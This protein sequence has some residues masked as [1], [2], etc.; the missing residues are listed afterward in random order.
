MASNITAG[1]LIVSVQ[2][3][4]TN[5]KK[6]IDTAKTKMQGMTDKINANKAAITS[7]GAKFTAVGGV[8]T[9]ALFLASKKVASFADNMAKMGKRTGESAATLSSLSFAAERSGSDIATIEKAI[10]R[11]AVNALDFSKGI[12]EAK[13]AFEELGI[14]V[15]NADGSLKSGSEIL[16]DFAEATKDMTDDTKKAALAQEIF[17]RAGTALLPFFKEGRDGIAAL[18]AEAV[19]YGLA[20]T[21]VQAAQ[22]EDFMD[23]LSNVKAAFSGITKGLVDGLIPA[24]TPVINKIA[25]ITAEVGDFI[26][27][28]KTFVTILLGVAGAFG[29]IALAIGPLLLGVASLPF[30][31]SGFAA[32]SGL[33]AVGGPF[34]LGAL[35]V[36]AAITSIAMNWDMVVAVIKTGWDTILKPIVNMM[37]LAFNAV[38]EAVKLAFD[39]IWDK[40]SAVISNIW[41][42]LTHLIDGFIDGFDSVWSIV[43]TVF[44]AIFNFIAGENG[45]IGKIYSSFRWLLDKLG[46]ELPEAGDLWADIG[47]T[48]EDAAEGIKGK[49]AGMKDAFAQNMEDNREKHDEETKI[50][51]DREIAATEVI[52]KEDEKRTEFKEEQFKMIKGAGIQFNKESLNQQA[53]DFD[54]H[55]DVLG[56]GFDGFYTE[57]KESIPGFFDK[58]FEGVAQNFSDRIDEMGDAWVDS[59]SEGGKFSDVF[60]F[61]GESLE[62]T[63]EAAFVDISGN[64]LQS[65]LDTIK[66]KLLKSGIGQTITNIFSGGGGASGAISGGLGALGSGAAG[67]GSVL[68]GGAGIIA[69]TGGIAAVGVGAYYAGKKIAESLG[70][71]HTSQKQRSLKGAAKEEHLASKYA[72]IVAAQTDVATWTAANVRLGNEV[73]HWADQWGI[74]GKELTDRFGNSLMYQL[75]NDKMFKGKIP[76]ATAEQMVAI[77]KEAISLYRQGELQSID[78]ANTIKGFHAGGIIPGMLGKET[79]IQALSGEEVITRRDPR[80]STN[81]GQGMQIVITGNNISSMLDIDTVAR[82]AGDAVMRQLAMQTKFKR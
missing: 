72:K 13:D 45:V 66:E 35:A 32:L 46:V 36:A 42:M 57:Q 62:R 22:G 58:A 14:T 63:F 39:F 48:G 71:K 52:G 21:D 79:L 47:K 69:A 7:A 37:V 67:I 51:E 73:A 24:L 30:L 80:H 43:K 29:A 1:N 26:K 27:N 64:I 65:F 61:M 18:Q 41:D 12:G 74:Q 19:K 9:G 81:I 53:I 28:N 17:G 34:I 54:T 20:I 68:A 55:L 40:V 59:L 44:T 2:A 56:T 15:T 33:L 11:V 75:M 23:S 70:M 49:W 38:G 3:Q 4:L 31:I 77:G 5:F 76:K 16:L 50:I 82:R 10:K 25:G 78:Q 6:G 60:K 8:I